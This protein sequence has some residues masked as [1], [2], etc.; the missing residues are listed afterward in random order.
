VRLSVHTA[1]VAAAIVLALAGYEYFSKHEYRIGPGT[2][3]LI[4]LLL[5]ARYIV[6]LQIRKR[7]RLAQEVPKRPLGLDV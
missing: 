5:A 3:A 1:G 2:L 6:Q 7:N 4:G